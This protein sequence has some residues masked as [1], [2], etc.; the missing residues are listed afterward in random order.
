M[1]AEALPQRP[2]GGRR[3]RTQD[4]RP[5]KIAKNG[6]SGN[7]RAQPSERPDDLPEYRSSAEHNQ[8]F[9]CELEFKFIPKIWP[10]DQHIVHSMLNAVDAC[11]FRPHC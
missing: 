7:E 10:V 4:S 6:I 1:D 2:A 9:E 11:R 5:S 8:N 3:S